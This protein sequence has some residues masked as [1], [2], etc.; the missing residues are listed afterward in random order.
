M[1]PGARTGDDNDSGE[2]EHHSPGHESGSSIHSRGGWSNRSIHPH[3]PIGPHDA[4]LDLPPGMGH[5]GH[6]MVL[7]YPERYN[8][9]AW[10]P[11]SP[12]GSKPPGHHHLHHRASWGGVPSLAPISAEDPRQD[13]MGIAPSTSWGG[14][15]PPGP[16]MIPKLETIKLET[17]TTPP[18][19]TPDGWYMSI[20]AD[21]GNGPFHHPQSAGV[22]QE[23]RLSPAT[24]VDGIKALVCV[25]FFRRKRHKHALG[26]YSFRSSVVRPDHGYWGRSRPGTCSDW[27]ILPFSYVRA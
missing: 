3:Q 12:L 21:S 5:P 25:R 1:N 4:M 18:N 23:R 10:P 11:L 27:G 7:A 9:L 8:Q 22:K 2:G 16:P 19:T 6:P 13:E 20:G 17:S 15:G 26:F 14:A 24:D